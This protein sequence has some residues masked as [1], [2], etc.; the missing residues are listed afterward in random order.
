MKKFLMMALMV[1]ATSS[2]FAGDSPALKAVMSAKTYAEAEAALKANLSQMLNDAER[3]KAYN[4]LVDLAME[5]VSKE[6]NAKAMA[7]IAVN[8]KDAPNIDYVGYYDAIYN[9]VVNAFECEKYDALPNEKGQVKPKFHKKNDDRLYPRRSE[10]INGGVFYQEKEDNDKAFKLLDLYVDSATAPLFAAH[11]PKADA[12]LSNIAFYSA[13]NALQK[14]DYARAERL[15]DMALTDSVNGDNAY[16]VKLAAMQKQLT[17]HQDSIAYAQ[18]LETLYAEQPNRAVVFESL[19]AIYSSLDNKD[20][21]NSLITNRLATNPDDWAA[22]AYR[23]QLL[24]G[25]EK[26]EEAI[27]DFE[28]ARKADPSNAFVE[29]ALGISY[30]GIASQ[31]EN[32]NQDAHGNLSK[33]VVAKRD[34]YLKTAIEH[35]EAS[36]RL[37]KNEEYRSSWSHNLYRCYYIVYGEEDPRTKEMSS[38]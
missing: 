36:R 10:L 27:A 35:F 7:E 8:A 2:A 11:D 25:E 6:D 9:A 24:Q 37:D 17:N 34:D 1:L 4:K 18:K 21:L 13:Y 12:N 26:Y 30:M 19:C 15:S 38:Y 28:A 14:E 16:I 32:A 5:K 23:G 33:E 20:K 31:Y 29:A 3:A 22:H